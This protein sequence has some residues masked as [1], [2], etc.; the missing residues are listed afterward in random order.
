VADVSPPLI[1]LAEHPR[2]AW[3]IRRTKAMASLAGFIAAGAGS[4]LHGVPLADAALRGL[5]GAV[6]GYL[7]GWFAAIVIWRSMLEAEARLVVEQAAE[8]RRRDRERTTRP[9]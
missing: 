2:A 8:R 3:A 4:A 1:G 7:A 6:V 5:G 9:E